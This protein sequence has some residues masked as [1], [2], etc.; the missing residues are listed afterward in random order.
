VPALAG[1]VRDAATGRL[2]TGA[3]LTLVPL[4]GQLP[5][6]PPILPAGDSAAVGLALDIQ[7][8]TG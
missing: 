1:A 6:G 8:P 3:A 5:Q 4:D 2:L 7:L